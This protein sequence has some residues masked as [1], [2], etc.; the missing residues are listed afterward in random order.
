MLEYVKGKRETMWKEVI[1]V[2]EYGTAPT[3]SSKT[4]EVMRNFSQ[5][6]SLRDMLLTVIVIYL[7]HNILIY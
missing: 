1:R 3:V 5:E 7:L 2:L 4:D 6:S